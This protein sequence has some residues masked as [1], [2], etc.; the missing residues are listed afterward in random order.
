MFLFFLLSSHFR[1][2]TLWHTSL[3]TISNLFKSLENFCQWTRQTSPRTAK[4]ISLPVQKAMIPMADPGREHFQG[5]WQPSTV[6]QADIRK[7]D[8][9][10]RM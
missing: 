10:K 5:V 6:F 3:S 9:F 7:P 4:S 2:T 8:D 1:E